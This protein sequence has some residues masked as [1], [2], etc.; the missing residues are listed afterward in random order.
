MPLVLVNS[1]DDPRWV[2]ASK[3]TKRATQCP[4]TREWLVDGVPWHGD[5]LISSPPDDGSVFADM[6]ASGKFVWKRVEPGPLLIPPWHDGSQMS[7]ATAAKPSAVNVDCVD[8][9]ALSGLPSSPPTAT[10]TPPDSA[11]RYVTLRIDP[12]SKIEMV[13]YGFKDV[14]HTEWV[15][16][17]VEKKA[18]STPEKRPTAVMWAAQRIWV[19]SEGK[20]YRGI[21]VY[22][23][24]QTCGVAAAKVLT[25]DVEQWAKESK[26]L[27]EVYHDTP[28]RAN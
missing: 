20:N 28:V 24:I 6:E 8:V 9:K 19:G 13:M 27:L 16:T 18:M 15:L 3:S 21:R 11:D 26:V 12:K 2:Q 25:A 10:Y 22:V 23:N 17:A 7:T 5:V 4:V 1:L 14:A